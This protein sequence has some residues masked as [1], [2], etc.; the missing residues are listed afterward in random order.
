MPDNVELHPN[1]KFQPESLSD[2]W[3]FYNK[4][5]PIF[6]W[7]TI[8]IKLNKPV[9]DT[10]KLY[11]VSHFGIDKYM[12]GTYKDGWVI[13][14]IRE[15]GA[16]YEICYDDVPPHVSVSGTSG[17]IRVQ[18]SD[19]GSGLKYIKGFVDGKFVLLEYK[20]KNNIYV[21]KLKNAPVLRTGGMH[22]LKIIAADKL[23]NQRIIMENFK[24]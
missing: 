17:N 10:D 22:M 6:G 18:A 3:R 4:S 9:K 20:E 13:T 2:S 1:V 24:Y 14:K 5:Y 19:S 21:C 23:D 12:G 11:V 7:A 15:L 8:K 16:E